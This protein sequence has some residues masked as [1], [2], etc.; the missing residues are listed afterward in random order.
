MLARLLITLAFLASAQAARRRDQAEA[1]DAERLHLSTAPS[2]ANYVAPF[3]TVA[4][5][6]ERRRIIFHYTG[7]TL[8][9]FSEG[10]A[11]TCALSDADAIFLEPIPTPD[12]RGSIL[13]QHIHKCAGSSMC[14]LASRNQETMTGFQMDGH[15]CNNCGD[16]CRIGSTA[17]VCG[18]NE[19]TRCSYRGGKGDI[20]CEQRAEIAADSTFMGQERFV[21]NATCEGVTY[22]IMLREPLDRLISNTKYARTYGWK[23]TSDEVVDLV[24]PG[25]PVDVDSDCTNCFTVE[26]TTFAYDNMFTR[27]LIGESGLYLAA[28]DVTREHLEEAKQ[29]LSSYHVV[30]ILDNFDN[31]TAQLTESFGWKVTS[32]GDANAGKEEEEPVFSDE[33]LETLRTANALDYELYC[34]GR[35]LAAARTKQAEAAKAAKQK[36]Q[37]EN[38]QAQNSHSVSAAPVRGTDDVADVPAPPTANST[39]GNSSSAPLMGG[40]YESPPAAAAEPVSDRKVPAPAPIAEPDLTPPAPSGAKSTSRG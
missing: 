4:Y 17:E 32:L 15:N 34:F 39:A 28:G 36:Q 33:Q 1:L 5:S 35:S 20:S 31:E 29:R 37:R 11:S 38:K 6:V 30:T 12:D 23:A 7:E 2:A 25:T 27:T 10:D 13:W 14:S 21:D 22:G 8:N 24:T 18:N 40:T 19:D 16:T 26:R 3:R 9:I